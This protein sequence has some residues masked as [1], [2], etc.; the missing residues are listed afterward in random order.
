MAFAIKCLDCQHRT[1]FFPASVSCPRCGSQWREAEYD[2][3]TLTSSWPQQLNARPFD[4]WRYR[5]LLPVRNSNPMLALGEGGT[6]LLPAVNLG[7]MLGTPQLYIKDERQGPTGSFKDRQAAV[8]IAALKEAGIT[9]MVAASTGNVAI[10]YSAYASRAGIKLWAFVTSL[11]PAVKMREI[12]LYGSQVVKVTGSYDQAKQV[13]AEFAR[14]RKLYQDLGARTITS[15]EAM[16]TIAFE[17]AEQLALAQGPK[18]SNNGGPTVWHAP[19]WYVQAISGGMGPLGVYKGFWELKQMGLVDRIPSIAA[20]QAD[21]CAPMVLSFQQGLERAIPV[22]TPRTHI[23]TLATGDPGRAYTRLRRQ[24]LETHGTFESVS[25]EEAF[26]AMHVLAKMEGI[27]AEPAAAVGFAGL[28]KLVR[29]GVIRQMDT[30]VVNCT[31]HTMPAEELVLGP[32]WTRDVELP[33]AQLETPQEGLLAA[34]NQVT[35]SKFRRVAIIDD[36]P[37]AR[38]LIRR[39]LQSQGD[40]S[41]FEAESGREGIE[42]CRREQPD[43]IILD[44]MMPEMDGFAVLDVLKADQRTAQIPVIVATAKELTPDEKTRLGTQ[45]QALMQKGDFLN[46]EFLAEVQALI[47]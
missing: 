15:V 27:S 31:G 18:A 35:P 16:K 20:I 19:D 4:L 22:E 30:I 9:E 36:T 21:G 41:I 3:D 40:Y 17:I 13:A 45:I 26:R 42:V 37:D 23:E 24:V 38:R 12:A 5:E 10:S 8:T 28:F 47:H 7:M 11:V 2:Y 44:L 14:Q 34:L 1:P 33:A 29:A 25:D 43:L 6:P 39:I 32:N 46:D